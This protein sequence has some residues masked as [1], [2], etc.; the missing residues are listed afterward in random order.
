MTSWMGEGRPVDVVYFDFSKAFDSVVS[1]NTL[2]TKLGKHGVD[3][4]A[5]RRIEN[6][7]GSRAQ[8]AVISS[9]ESSWRPAAT[10][11]PPPRILV[12]KK[13]TM[14][15]PRANGILGPN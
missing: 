12:A 6:G 4:W 11:V 14:S 8:R 10:D 7:L 5:V 9:A 2:I 15:Q 1:H 3:E 13:L